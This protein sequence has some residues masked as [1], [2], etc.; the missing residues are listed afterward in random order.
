MTT[1]FLRLI[2][3]LAG[4]IPPS[5]V[6]AQELPALNIPI[7]ETSLSGISSGG[8]MAAQFQIAH[9]S[10]VKGAGI[11]AAGP[12]NCARGDAIKAT[13]LCSCT[14]DPLGKTC[15]VTDSSADVPGLVDA[16]RKAAQEKR[17]DDPA[18]VAKQRVLTFAGGKDP[19]VPKAVVAQLDA[20]YRALGMPESQLSVV[21]KADAGHTMPTTDYGNACSVTNEPYMGKC[22]MDGA[23]D[24]LNWIYGP[25]KPARTGAA[26]GKF[27][28]FDQRPYIPSKSPAWSVGMDNGGWLYVPDACAKG[29]SCRLHVALHG[30][31]QGQ[32]YLPL[33]PVAPGA[34]YYGTTF[35]KNAGYDRWADTNHL[36][37]LFPQA[38]TTWNNPNGCWDWWG[39]TGRHYADK[40]GVQ[41]RALRAMVDR[42]ASGV[43]PVK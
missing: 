28:A 30:C 29:E 24:I 3:L 36:V 9:S 42:L 41:I 43:K 7:A 8:F 38:S 11:V 16:T 34:L 20:Y 14:L 13:T 26:K 37:I 33:K 5:A 18:N 31:K 23:G 10:I 4:L 27:L 40:E 17:I 22:A 15:Q 21:E 39:Y 12:W 2:A 6:L 32:S 35:V 25:M 1:R 19:I